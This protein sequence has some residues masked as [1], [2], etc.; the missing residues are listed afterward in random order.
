[1][2]RLLAVTSL[3]LLALALLAGCGSAEFGKPLTISEPTDIADILSDP[4]AWNGKRVMVEGTITEVCEMAGCWVLI[5]GSGEKDLI[6]FKVE[7]GVI[8]FPMEA[9][10]KTA[11]AEGVVAVRT[12][13]VD[14]QIAEGEHHADEAGTTFD[15]STVTGPKVSVQIDGEGAVVR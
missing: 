2:K 5:R 12:L 6:R 1:M 14:E 15:P 11:K 7:D 9:S 3:F 10:G 13:S 4:K 8:V